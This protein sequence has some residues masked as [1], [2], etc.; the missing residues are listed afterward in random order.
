[1]TLT[2]ISELGMSQTPYLPYSWDIVLSDFFLSGELKHKLQGCSYDSK[3]DFL[4]ITDLMENLEILLLHP[5]F[6]EWISHVFI[7]L[8]KMVKSISK[9]S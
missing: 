8:W 9:H 6:D 7:L 2:K 4:A 1:V 5:V 3:L